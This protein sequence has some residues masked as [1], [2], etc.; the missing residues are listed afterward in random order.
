MKG[1]ILM[2]S[3]RVYMVVD[4]DRCW[5]CKACEVACKQE[6]GLGTGFSPMKV[7]EIGPRKIDGG[8]HRDFVPTMC[9]H[10]EQAACMEACPT[11]AIFREV[12][13]TVQFDSD[14]CIGCGQC[15][16]VCPYGVIGVNDEGK[17]V[18]CILC[19]D[20]RKEG[21]LPSCAQ[22]CPGR[23]LSFVSESKLSSLIE[24][25]HYWSA[26]SIVYVS[27]KW[28]SLGEAMKGVR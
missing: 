26:G 28:A 4:L 6:L 19:S 2:S 13:G 27:D 24:G 1:E 7:V 16:T 23:A 18:K 10:C 3:D 20:R 22:H 9:Q 21:L 25:R 11:G 14:L 12:D 15:E 8:L 5:G 17:A